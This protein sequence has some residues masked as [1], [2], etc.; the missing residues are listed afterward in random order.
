M[1]ESELLELMATYSGNALTAFTIYISFTFAYLTV[2]FIVGRKLS[3]V[4]AIIVSVLYV[5]SAM[6]TVLA[7]IGQISAMRA[8]QPDLVESA[9]YQRITLMDGDMWLIYM[10]ILLVSG[11]FGSLYFMY[12]ARKKDN[13]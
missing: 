7:N 9:V 12:D 11:I 13:G 5:F 2:A 1:S 6:S 8:T 4:Q 10:P 3:R